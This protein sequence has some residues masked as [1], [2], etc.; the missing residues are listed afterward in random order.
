MEEWLPKESRESRIKEVA[1]YIR[2]S[3]GDYEE[4]LSKHRARMVE[5]CDNKGWKYVEYSEIGSGD[6]IEYREKFKQLLADLREDLYDAVVVMDYDRLGRGNQ[7][8]QHIIAET[9]KET[10]TYIVTAGSYNIMDLNDENDED[11]SE[12]RGFIARQ[13]YKQIKKRLVRGKKMSARLGNWSNGKAPYGYKYDPKRKGLSVNDEQ[14]KVYRMMVGWF[15][16]GLSSKEI[17]WKLNSMNI[18]SYTGR[19]WSHTTI[20][21]LLKSEVHLGRIISNKYKS[22]GREKPM[23]KRPKNEWLVMENCHKA[24]KTRQEHEQILEVA[25]SNKK[26]SH[27][28]VK[29]KHPLSSLVKCGM[30]GHTLTIAYDKDLDTHYF[31]SCQYTH[32]DEG[33]CSNRGGKTHLVEDIID[34]TILKIKESIENEISKKESSGYIDSINKEIK[35]LEGQ[36]KLKNQ[37][38]DKIDEAFEMG[39]YSVDRFNERRIKTEKEIG[40]LTKNVESLNEKL[41]S[42]DESSNAERLSL[43]D[44]FLQE[45]KEEK[46]KEDMNGLYKD[47]IKSIDWYRKEDDE[48]YIS[49]N[50]L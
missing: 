33:K 49:V 19:R 27:S 45:S 18:P 39:V 6:S 44:R 42:F 5:L 38:L 28:T 12:I 15:L 23:T 22:N 35:S 26:N 43:I 32:F 46:S 30:C 20:L 21:Q 2:K 25:S 16:E 9:F 48:I 24:L 41:L 8:D 40:D 37:A 4:D 11:M 3:R 36:L 17:A 34:Q 50:F 13:E 10:E 14:S 47:I 1:I 7:M 29:P 31:Q